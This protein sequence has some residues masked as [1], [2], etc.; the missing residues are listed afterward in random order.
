ML[1]A[2]LNL[3]CSKPDPKW[4]WIYKSDTGPTL[5]TSWIKATPAYL[6]SSLNYMGFTILKY[7]SVLSL[8]GF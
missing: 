3:T 2:V 6:G 7:K 4:K 1:V 5:C 8:F